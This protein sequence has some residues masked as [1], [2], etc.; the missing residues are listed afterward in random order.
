ML[1]SMKDGSHGRA[2]AI[3]ITPL[4]FVRNSRPWRNK[5]LRAHF[6]A[7]GL[8]SGWGS[9]VEIPQVSKKLTE[10]PLKKADAWLVG[11]HPHMCSNQTWSYLQGIKK[12]MFFTD[13]RMLPNVPLN[14]LEVQDFTPFNKSEPIF[15]WWGQLSHAASFHWIRKWNFTLILVSLT[16]RNR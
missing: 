9:N 8:V 4:L 11:F 6:A 15:I 10:I 13:W 12:L 2:F 14:S 1:W 5:S 7:S 3:P 16:V